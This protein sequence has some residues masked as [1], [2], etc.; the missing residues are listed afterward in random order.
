MAPPGPPER[1]LA[2]EAK[3]CHRELRIDSRKSSCLFGM[4][5]KYVHIL[6]GAQSNRRLQ[7]FVQKHITLQG[8]SRSLRT[9][10]RPDLRRPVLCRDAR[11]GRVKWLEGVREMGGAPRNPTP[12]NR[13]L[14]RIVKPSGCHCTDGHLTSRVFTEDQQVSQSADPPWEHFPLLRGRLHGQQP[15][16]SRGR[17]VCSP[18]RRTMGSSS[19]C[20][21]R[22]GEGREATAMP[23]T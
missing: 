22:R 14:V 16:T 13:F 4:T 5:S 10:L 11:C 6:R 12:R 19:H 23:W 20:H 1:W 7:Q 2:R 17:A 3:G 9:V 15:R 18:G 8:V 21:G